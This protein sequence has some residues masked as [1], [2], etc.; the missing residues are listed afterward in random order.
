MRAGHATSASAP[1]AAP[2][3]LLAAAAL[4]AALCALLCA[5]PA[6]AGCLFSDF[7]LADSKLYRPGD[8]CSNTPASVG[9]SQ[10]AVAANE[11][12]DFA[13]FRQADPQICRRLPVLRY[14]CGSDGLWYYDDATLTTDAAAPPQR[15]P[16]LWCPQMGDSCTFVHSAADASY[17]FY[18]AFSEDRQPCLQGL[19]FFVDPRTT[20]YG[21]EHLEC[22]PVQMNSAAR[23]HWGYLESMQALVY[24]DSGFQE[25]YD[26]SFD[27]VPNLRRLVMPAN[28]LSGAV[29]DGDYSIALPTLGQ[30]ET[31]NL[32]GNPGPF[33]AAL[34]APALKPSGWDSPAQVFAVPGC[35]LQPVSTIAGGSR[36]RVSCPETPSPTSPCPGAAGMRIP[37]VRVGGWGGEEGGGRERQRGQRREGLLF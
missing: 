36:F 10:G 24:V 29:V 33:S 4:C 11:T 7:P 35:S 2:L 1:R 28:R 21:Y 31:L 20:A 23:R 27:A 26:T 17:T 34:V 9:F 6:A 14:R 16:Q 15:D 8:I 3:P 25:T 12:C 22:G 19:S 13:A 32:T 18:C 5:A 30:L 37:M